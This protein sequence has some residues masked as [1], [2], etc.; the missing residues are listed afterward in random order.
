MEHQNIKTK[1]IKTKKIRTYNI[2]YNKIEHKNIR[3]R[4]Y[5]IQTT[6]T[7]NIIILQHYNK[8]QQKIK[9]ETPRKQKNRT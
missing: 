7:D 8:E 5:T 3:T 6:K 2:E 4:E 9:A 1:N